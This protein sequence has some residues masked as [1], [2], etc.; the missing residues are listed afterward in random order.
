ML[1]EIHQIIHQN[2]VFYVSPY[3]NKEYWQHLVC[4]VFL[5]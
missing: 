5:V 2:E 1:I 3:H 4:G